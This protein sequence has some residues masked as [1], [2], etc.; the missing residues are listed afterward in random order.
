MI[1]LNAYPE[2]VRADFGQWGQDIRARFP[3]WMT[4]AAAEIWPRCLGRLEIGQPVT[5]EIIAR[6]PFGVWIDIGVGW[7]AVVLIPEMRDEDGGRIT[8]SRFPAKGSTVDGRVV[9]FGDG[10]EIHVTQAAPA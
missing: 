8:Y 6:A 7:P 10:G 2:Q 9:G 3:A 5:G 1:D 4:P